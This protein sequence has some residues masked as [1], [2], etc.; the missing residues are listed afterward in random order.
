M[1]R[2]QFSFVFITLSIT[3]TSL[4]KLE[5]SQ[6]IPRSKIKTRSPYHSPCG[7]VPK[8]LAYLLAEPGSLNPVVLSV[9]D[10]IEDGKVPHQPRDY[11]ELK[12]KAA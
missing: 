7:N 11:P 9:N 4:L 10:Q 12:H 5:V 8:G 2:L 1:I 3:S 6:P